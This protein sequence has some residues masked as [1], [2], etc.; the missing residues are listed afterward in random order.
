LALLCAAAENKRNT[1]S[2]KNNA[3]YYRLFLHDQA[4]VKCAIDKTVMAIELIAGG[5]GR[6][7][8]SGERTYHF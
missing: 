8:L 2:L 6:C 4:R 3:N 1:F 7:S 5:V